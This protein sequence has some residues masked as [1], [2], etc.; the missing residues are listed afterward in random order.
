MRKLTIF[1]LILISVISCSETDTIKPEE[2]E[3]DSTLIQVSDSTLFIWIEKTKEITILDEGVF[4]ATIEDDKIAT[5]S[6]VG[7]TLTVTAKKGGNTKILINS[8][9]ET[10]RNIN[11]AVRDEIDGI[12]REESIESVIDV[13]VKDANI[14]SIIIYEL[15]EISNKR[16]YSKY[17]INFEKAEVVVSLP[18]EVNTY[19]GTFEWQHHKLLFKYNDIT[20][21]YIT[22]PKFEKF[23]VL[24]L[25]QDLTEKYKVLYP[26]AGVSKVLLTRHIVQRGFGFYH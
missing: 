24:G 22:E 3:Q 17:D 26:E 6:L 9:N 13:N 11:V 8:K 25:V 18:Y 20:E 23:F 16:K 5:V 1:L 4:T 21:E 12:W 7:N 15:K 14:E 10:K 2:E 19:N